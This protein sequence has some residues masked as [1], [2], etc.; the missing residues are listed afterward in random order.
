MDRRL[1]L[2]SIKVSSVGA[3]LPASTFLNLSTSA[4]TEPPLRPA[5]NPN[6]V[7]AKRITNWTNWTG[8]K[9]GVVSVGGI[10][11]ICL[12]RRF[13]PDV[14]F[15]NF[16]RTIAIDS[17]GTDLNFMTA[18]RK[19]Q[20]DNNTIVC[21]PHDGL[22]L[23]QT[24]LPRIT[25]AVTGLDMVILVSGMGGTVG[26]TATPIVARQLKKLGVLTLA[27]VLMPYAEEGVKRQKTAAAGLQTLRGEVNALLPVCNNE[28]DD[29][30]PNWNWWNVL[31]VPQYID[32]VYG[33]IVTPL[34]DPGWV[35]VDFSDVRDITL[36]QTGLCAFG[37]GLSCGEHAAQQAVVNAIEQTPLGKSRLQQARSA[38]VTFEHGRD[39]LQ[40][41]ISLAIQSIRSHLSPDCHFIYGISG[42]DYFSDT[43]MVNIL[44]N[45][46]Q[47]ADSRLA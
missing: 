3:V 35:N 28:F 1:F 42:F 16:V 18:D 12:P 43:V 25:D 11:R 9:I 39:V 5:I 26:T 47:E 40:S 24:I 2:N 38:M 15:P 44:A 4:T 29:F 14:K 46:I 22:A 31:L 23:S 33:N 37:H 21:D 45:G 41:D 34:C 20:L 27:I 8:P 17:Y 19:V 32:A 36:N 30:D 7:S 6:P 13:N 10:G